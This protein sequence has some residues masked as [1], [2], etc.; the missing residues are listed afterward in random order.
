MSQ[1]V[2]QVLDNLSFFLCKGI[3]LM[4]FTATATP[5]AWNADT[6]DEMANLM[7]ANFRLIALFLYSK[8]IGRRLFSF[9]RLEIPYF[10]ALS[11]A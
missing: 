1:L 10:N 9:D 8:L 4:H 3:Y 2:R 5:V 11:E 7:Q 6:C